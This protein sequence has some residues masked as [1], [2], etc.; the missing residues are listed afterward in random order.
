MYS[1]QERSELL[2]TRVGWAIRSAI[3]EI[4][5]WAAL[6]IAAAGTVAGEWME[7]R[8]F[9]ALAGAIAV[10]LFLRSLVDLRATK[11]G[12]RDR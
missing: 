2:T 12:L 6:L 7:L 11:P 4:G 10:S 5:G 9:V 8:L 1:E 3:F